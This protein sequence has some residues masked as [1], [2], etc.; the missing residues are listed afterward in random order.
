MQGP[1]F[2]FYVLALNY[3]ETLF[4]IKTQMMC[5]LPALDWLYERRLLVYTLRKFLVLLCDG[6]LTEQDF[7]YFLVAIL[8]FVIQ[9]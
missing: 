6:N 1:T 5:I 8:I 4:P 9:L 3:K 2:I 7:I